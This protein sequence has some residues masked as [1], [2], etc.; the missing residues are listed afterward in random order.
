VLLVVQEQAD[1][2]EGAGPLGES[3][4][5]VAERSEQVPDDPQGGL[6]AA[7]ADDLP[8]DGPL[9]PGRAQ[10]PGLS[11]GLCTRSFMT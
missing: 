11:D 6:A 7:A 1:A 2:L 3:P 5:R 4:G 10:P 8:A 9:E